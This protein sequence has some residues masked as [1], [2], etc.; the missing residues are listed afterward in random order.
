MED[1]SSFAQLAWLVPTTNEEV[2]SRI[3][4]AFAKPNKKTNTDDLIAGR[5]SGERERE[6]CPHELTAW[7]PDGR[8]DLREYELRRKLAY[9]IASSPGNINQIELVRVH[10]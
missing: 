10:S 9:D 4:D 5:G 3:E 2:C 1:T 7:Y 6:N 8:A